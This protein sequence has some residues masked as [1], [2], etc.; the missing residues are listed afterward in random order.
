MPSVKKILQKTSK[1]TSLKAKPSNAST[2]KTNKKASTTKA[3]KKVSPAKASTAKA[4][5]KA[6]NPATSTMLSLVQG[7]LNRTHTTPVNQIG[8]SCIQVAHSRLLSNY[9]SFILGI[10]DT[11]RINK[12]TNDFNKALDTYT[13]TETSGKVVKGY[14]GAIGNVL[15]IVIEDVVGN[16]NSIYKNIF[17]I[18][19]HQIII[20]KLTTIRGNILDAT[21]QPEAL[22]ENNEAKKTLNPGDRSFIVA[23]NEFMKDT[24]KYTNNQGVD[25]RQLFV[26]YIGIEILLIPS[27]FFWLASLDGT[28]D[29]TG[30][31]PP[32]NIKNLM[33]NELNSV[34]W[35]GKKY[36]GTDYSIRGDVNFAKIKEANTKRAYLKYPG[37]ALVVKGYDS[38]YLNLGFPC[39]LIQNSWGVSWNPS[40]L[41]P[42]RWI[43]ATIINQLIYEVV[44][45]DIRNIRGHGTTK[46]QKP[47]KRK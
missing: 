24:N 35:N 11:L 10:N 47:N 41:A 17:T 38:N 32:Q 13:F 30:C 9:F 20:S 39:Y 28:D 40:I 16:I 25:T 12:I 4:N 23:I 33:P 27:I 7:N 19:E 6:L 43:D 42:G 31:T 3:N 37:H 34:T 26:N 44:W 46:K 45:I 22:I 1:S 21:K 2:A 5:K 36:I 18:T 29:R 14:G 8:D 15:G